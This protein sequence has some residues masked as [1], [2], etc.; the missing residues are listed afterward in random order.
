MLRVAALACLGACWVWAQDAQAAASAQDAQAIVSSLRANHPDE[1]L[2]LA[3]QALQKTP[4]NAQLLT[5]EGLAFKALG[6]PDKALSAFRQALR[7]D[8]N[9][10]A[11]LE[12]AAQIEYAAAEQQAIPDLDH[13][14]VLRPGEPTAH[15]SG[16]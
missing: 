4:R 10:L 9:Y 12:G 3:R 14:L 5:L 13:L 15:A 2:Q 7:I 16:Q 8:P 11:A 6:Q 1:A